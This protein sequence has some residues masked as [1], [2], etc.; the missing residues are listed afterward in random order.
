MQ[1]LVDQYHGLIFSAELIKPFGEDLNDIMRIL[2]K[3]QLHDSWK[4]VTPGD[5]PSAP[6]TFTP[7]ADQPGLIDMGHLQFPKDL[8]HPQINIFSQM[9]LNHKQEK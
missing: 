3:G 1:D 4:S 8:F 9:V 7:Q 5:H 2:V 6:G